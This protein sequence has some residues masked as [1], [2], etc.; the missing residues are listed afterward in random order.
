MTEQELLTALQRAEQTIHELD[1]VLNERISR[2]VD[3]EAML[4]EVVGGKRSLPSL[5]DCRHMANCLGAPKAKRTEHVRN[6][7]WR[8]NATTKNTLDS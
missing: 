6:Y 7:V 3:V 5:E 1:R 2:S 8:G 4:Y